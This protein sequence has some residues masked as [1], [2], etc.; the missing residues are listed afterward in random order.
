MLYKFEEISHLHL[1]ISSKCNAACPLCPRN[2][3]GYPMNQ[4]YVEHNMTL[5]EAKKIFSSKFLKQ[6]KN[7]VI[8]GNFGDA[9]MNTHT[10]DICRY[11]K[12][13]NPELKINI[14]TNGGARDAQFWIDLAKL[15][16][17]VF[18]CIDG[19]EDTHSIY[20]RNTLF[21][22]VIKNAETFISAG[23]NAG[24]KMIKFKHNAHQSGACQQLSKQMGFNVFLL[25]DDGR[26]NGPIFDKEKKLE[27][28]LGGDKWTGPVEFD[29]LA[30][31]NTDK[32]MIDV[33]YQQY[34][35]VIPI[36]HI[37]CE[38][39][40]SKSIYVSSTGDV[41]P[42][43]YTGFSPQTFR[44]INDNGFAMKQIADIMVNNNALEHDLETCTE[45]F[46][47]IEHS[48]SKPGFDQGRLITCNQSCGSGLK[49][50]TYHV[51][52]AVMVDHR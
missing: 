51:K 8:N 3:W 52:D 16:V 24:W 12:E 9:V 42:C 39:S 43:C 45:W 49:I 6:L 26:D 20:R 25:V 35:R 40:V 10:V 19:L 11:F 48:W 7:I 18:F 4:G 46:D 30:R 5:N 1:E 36:K 44:N 29:T 21:S 31:S 14:S 47:G 34:L 13:Q 23:G 33:Q 28:V 50:N 38:V 41:F 17:E 2:F 15:N 32:S 27:F 22:T 37:Q